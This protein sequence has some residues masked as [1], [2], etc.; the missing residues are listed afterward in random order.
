MKKWRGWIVL[1]LLLVGI[2]GWWSY[3]R[4]ASHPPSAEAVHAYPRVEDGQPEEDDF[5]AKDAEQR[6]LMLGA[7]A[8]LLR[9]MK[10]DPRPGP[11]EIAARLKELRME[12]VTME[13][14]VLTAVIGE[15]LRSGEDLP[16]GLAFA[17][18]QHGLLDG[19]PTLRVFLLD[20]LAVSDPQTAPA[21]AREVLETAKSGDEYAVALRSLTRP[22]PGR[23]GDTELVDRFGSLLDHPEWSGQAGFA[24]AFDLARFIGT[25]DAARK[26][27]AWQGNAALKSLAL[28]EFSAAHPAAMVEVL[29]SPDAASLEPIERASLMA[30][31]DPADASQ[32]AAADAYLRAQGLASDEAAAFLKVFPLAECDYR[33][34]IV[35]RESGTLFTG[36]HRGRGP[37][38][39][40]AGGGLDGRSD[41]VFTLLH[42]VGSPPHPAGNVG[43]TGG[44]PLTTGVLAC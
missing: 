13:P 24:N 36:W 3:Q 28:D 27:A 18:G 9:W 4:R 7:W 31:I 41:P 21:V 17:V 22:G 44:L 5:A 15:I 16:T 11:E 37:R 25:A 35:W 10:S 20:V 42:R 29:N 2:A 33:L 40:G 34:P 14:T 8:E 43:E 6:R 1:A 19:W 30:R 26:V 32:L 12:W 23:A 39:A 38:G